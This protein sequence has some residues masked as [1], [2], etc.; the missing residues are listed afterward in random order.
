MGIADEGDENTELTM[1][2]VVMLQRSLV[3]V[4]HLL[5]SYDEQP[6]PYRRH[7]LKEFALTM[8]AELCSVVPKRHAPALLYMVRDILPEA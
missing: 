7:V 4:R 2:M 1:D 8:V 5:D 3:T 6:D